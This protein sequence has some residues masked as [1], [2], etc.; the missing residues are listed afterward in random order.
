MNF[1]SD[2][3]MSLS[4]LVPG[5]DTEEKFN[6]CP[7]KDQMNKQVNGATQP[8]NYVQTLVLTKVAK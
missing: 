5:P 1:S 7:V 8:A 4:S 6:I 2:D 3:Y